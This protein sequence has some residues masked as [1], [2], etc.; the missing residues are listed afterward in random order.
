MSEIKLNIGSKIIR[1]TNR[2]SPNK[3]PKIR[4]KLVV[5]CRNKIELIPYNEIMYL[6]ASSN[7][8]SIFLQDGSNR[9]VSK[10]LKETS[11]Q[12]LNRGFIRIHK[13]FVVKIDGVRMVNK[14]TYEIELNNG[15][16]L[17][18]SRNKRKEVLEL[19]EF[20]N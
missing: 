18:V 20:R 4:N 5:T 15:V 11:S 2:L 9:L 14:A 12:L 10:T 7:Y 3:S 1:L 19:F 16:K 8:T 6:K 17:S 13:S